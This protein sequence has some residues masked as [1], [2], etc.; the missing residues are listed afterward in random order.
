MEYREDRDEENG[1]E[2]ARETVR[3]GRLARHSSKSCAELSR[4]NGNWY[5]KGKKDLPKH[6]LHI[7]PLLIYYPHFQKDDVYRVKGC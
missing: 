7:R 3:S 1:V 2:Q 5:G 6:Q 4:A